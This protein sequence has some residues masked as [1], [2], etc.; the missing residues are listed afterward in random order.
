MG[1][2]LVVVLGLA[3]VLGAA[4]YYLNG[5]RGRTVEDVDAQVRPSQQLQNVREAAKRIEEDSQKRAD[6]LLQKSE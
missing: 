6:E 5:Q 3:V 2:I 1:R 4:Y